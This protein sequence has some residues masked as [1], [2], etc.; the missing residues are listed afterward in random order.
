[1]V[2][3]D[4][5]NFVIVVVFVVVVVVVVVVVKITPKKKCHFRIHDTWAFFFEQNIYEK[6]YDVVWNRT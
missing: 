1:M 2:H 3:I 5:I 4:S 6:L